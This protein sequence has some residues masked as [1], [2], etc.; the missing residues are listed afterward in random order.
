MLIRCDAEAFA[1]LETDEV[2]MGFKDVFH[3]KATR[4]YL[5]ITAYLH[6]LVMQPTS[7]IIRIHYGDIFVEHN[8]CRW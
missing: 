8:R 1:V 7:S 6:D 3:Q 2:R 5:F 4:A